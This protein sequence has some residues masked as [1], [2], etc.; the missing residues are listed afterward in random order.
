M[1]CDRA[2]EKEEGGGPFYNSNDTQTSW[3]MTIQTS[4][5]TTPQNPKPKNQKDIPISSHAPCAMLVLVA[6][7]NEKETTRVYVARVLF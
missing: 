2:D 7:K 1:T 5:S 3:L 4:T 6:T